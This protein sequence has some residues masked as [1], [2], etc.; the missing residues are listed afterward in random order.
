[1]PCHV[2]SARRPS[3]TG[4]VTDGAEVDTHGTDPLVA[5]SDGDGLSDGAELNTHATDPL[6]ADSDDDGFD[7]GV[8]VSAGSDPNDPGS[9]PPA[10]PSLSRWPALALGALL[11]AFARRALRRDH[12]SN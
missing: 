5:D 8:E 4:T 10:V 11:F 1:M 2:P 3:D 9:V 6:D 12:S 7:D